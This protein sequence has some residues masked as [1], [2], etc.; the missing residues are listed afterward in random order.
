MKETTVFFILTTVLML[1]AAVW[2]LPKIVEWINRE[3][4][5]F[6]ISGFQDLSQQEEKG[7]SLSQES[8]SSSP[9]SPPPVKTSPFF[10]SGVCNGIPC[11]EGTFC[12][13]VS[14]T[15]ISLSPPGT[16]PDTGYFS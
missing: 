15:C 1:L 4:A 5:H 10:L 11:P 14:Q 12:D 13:D 6:I 9:P 8:L 3:E 16:A 7:E 2:I